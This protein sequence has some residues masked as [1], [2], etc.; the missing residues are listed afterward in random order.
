MARD[1]R[2]DQEKVF[3]TLLE[4]FPDRSHCECGK[5]FWA[6]GDGR[7]LE[8]AWADHIMEEIAFTGVRIEAD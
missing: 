4:H 6:E 5:I 2:N 8:E 1:T 3:E 7:L